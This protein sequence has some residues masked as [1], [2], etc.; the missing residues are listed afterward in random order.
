MTGN[1]QKK[2]LEPLFDALPVEMSFI[3]AKDS[4]QY[5]N[6]EGARIFPRN[7]AVIG[8]KVQNCH[9]QKS[10]GKVQAI[11]DGFRKGIL[12]KAEFWID[13]KGK[14]I[15][16][17]YFPVRDKKGKYLGTLEATQDITEIQKI[18]GE[19]RLL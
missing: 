17:R 4:V 16:V 9:P 5:F 7:K 19:K 1:I 8:M 11:L 10:L 14:K 12:D 3:D 2:C 6:K 18:S 13:L 15:L